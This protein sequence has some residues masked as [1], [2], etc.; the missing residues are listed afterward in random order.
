MSTLQ[1]GNPL[2]YARP[3]DASAETIDG[4]PNYFYVTALAGDTM[5]LL[6]KGINPIRAVEAS[7]GNRV[8]A[9]LIGSSP[10]KHGSDDTPWQDLF[11]PDRGFVRYFGDNRHNGIRP[12]L[13]KG[14]AVLLPQ[15]AVHNSA[16]A[17]SRAHAV[18]LLLFQRA[19]VDGRAKGNVV[20]QG[21]GVISAAELVSQM[22]PTTKEVFANY[23][24]EIAILSMAD[25]GEQF[26]WQWINARRNPKLTLKETHSHPIG[27]GKA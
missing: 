18:P 3:Y 17:E 13:S 10:H 23:V 24:F 4:L 8:P 7:S 21:F 25:E 11:E 1:I 2:R 19:Q 6:D 27:S 14:N 22:N 12:E 16:S 20:F 5:P 26:D 15:F 9:I